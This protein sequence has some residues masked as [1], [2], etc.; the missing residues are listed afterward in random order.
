MPRGATLSPF[1]VWKVGRLGKV[2]VNLVSVSPRELGLTDRRK[3]T[4]QE[5]CSAALEQGLKF[6]PIEAIDQLF[7]QHKN[8]PVVECLHVAGE[9]IMDSSVNYAYIYALYVG[10]NVKPLP[11]SRNTRNA[12]DRIIFAQPYK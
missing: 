2:K 11:G 1:S 7:E 5:I 4:D 9:F 10:K 6:C 8:E 12:D 3:L